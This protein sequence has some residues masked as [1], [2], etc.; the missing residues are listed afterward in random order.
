MKKLST[1][2][3]TISLEDDVE[4]HATGTGYPGYLPFLADNG[5]PYFAGYPGY[6]GHEH[7]ISKIKISKPK[8]SIQKFLHIFAP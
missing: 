5:I 7:I 3:S 1:K 4:S 2:L 6:P 8:C